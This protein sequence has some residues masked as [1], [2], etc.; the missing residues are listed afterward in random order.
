MSFP[1]I[2]VAVKKGVGDL[3]KSLSHPG[4]MRDLFMLNSKRQTGIKLLHQ[5]VAPL[6]KPSISAEPKS[7]EGAEQL[8]GCLDKCV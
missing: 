1:K 2:V 6:I 3:T 4:L 5:M 8:A 7:P